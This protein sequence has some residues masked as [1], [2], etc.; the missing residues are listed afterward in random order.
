[1]AGGWPKGSRGL[2]SATLGAGDRFLG[3]SGVEIVQYAEGRKWVREAKIRS[4]SSGIPP[5]VPEGVR[6]GEGG[7]KLDWSKNEFFN[8]FG[9]NKL[10]PAFSTPNPLRNPRRDPR[11]QKSNFDLPD[12]FSPLG[13]LHDFDS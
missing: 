8:F 9:P 11:S 7:E 2:V 6:C 4:P 10:S 13:V 5:G 12:P 3:V 1:M